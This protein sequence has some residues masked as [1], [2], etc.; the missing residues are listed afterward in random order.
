MG[1][2]TSIYSKFNKKV[3]LKFLVPTVLVVALGVLAA[4][5]VV[6]MRVGDDIRKSAQAKVKADTA[7]IIE[8]LQAINRLR[9]QMVEG[10]AQRAQR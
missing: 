4:G 6:T 1:F 10:G 5:V 7:R 8:R 3:A 2:I 9:V